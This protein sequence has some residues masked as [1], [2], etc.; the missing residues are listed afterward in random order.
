M[1]LSHI[2]Q[3]LPLTTGVSPPPLPPSERITPRGGDV[4]D[5]LITAELFSRSQRQ[6]RFEEESRALRTLARVAANSPA[7][8]LDTLLH[9][10]VELCHADSAGLSLLETTPAG[11]RIFRWTHLSGVLRNHI[12][13]F[14]P[15][16]FS[17]C[18][19]CLDRG[20]AQLFSYPERYYH[21]LTIHHVPFVE[22][23]IVPLVEKT[24]L[25]TL[26]IVSH[27][28]ATRF[29]AEDVRIMSSLAEF[30]SSALEMTRLVDEEHQ[31][32]KQV[33]I[34]LQDRTATLRKL[35]SRLIGAQEDE[36]RRIAS[37]LHDGVGQY[38]AAVKINLDLMNDGTMPQHAELLA[39]CLAEVD[40]CLAETRTISHLLHPP[41][42]DEAGL[43]SAAQ[44]YIGEFSRR[45]K[46][47]TAFDGPAQLQRLP[48]EIEIVLFR[49][50]Q[51]N[52]TNVYR[53]SQSLKVDIR[54]HLDAG[55]IS[56]MIKDYGVGLQPGMVERFRNNENGFGVGLAGM[57]ERVHELKGSIDLQS[58]PH[59]TQITVTI[60]LASEAGT[61]NPESGEFQNHSGPQN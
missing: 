11:D 48:H 52:L 31:V 35:S 55:K 24:P 19:V 51:E 13:G 61:A 7:K 18:G 33:E 26:W 50:L 2:N 16:E 44:W 6:P 14:T 32:R 38:L 1:S 46:M 54:L 29:D 42:L 23:L 40:Q 57:R 12:G 4:A 56:L 8:L 34:E 28:P 27:N 9:L 47:A 17:P 36:R 22:A 39:D 49:A 60:P 5:V 45:S 41:L 3:S 25:G 15:R 43:L 21:Y 37:A 10:A 53:H 20:S 58:N 30:T 59:G